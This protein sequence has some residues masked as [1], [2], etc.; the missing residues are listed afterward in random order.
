MA[1]KETAWA[2]LTQ[3]Q[4][5]E[6]W[7][8]QTVSASWLFRWG[9]SLDSQSSSAAALHVADRNRAALARFQRHLK[10]CQR[11]ICPQQGEVGERWAPAAA[12]ADASSL[13][14]ALCVWPS[15]T[16]GLAHTEAATDAPQPSACEEA[17]MQHTDTVC[18]RCRPEGEPRISPAAQGGR[19]GGREREGGERRENA[20]LRLTLSCRSSGA[21]YT[22]YQSGHIPN[23]STVADQR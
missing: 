16:R 12:A 11:L 13:Q 22:C 8:R 2:E 23:H 17:P 15:R 21:E 3:L 19:E 7:R 14:H 4:L 20:A 1:L 18:P 6:G 5:T 9:S 10:S